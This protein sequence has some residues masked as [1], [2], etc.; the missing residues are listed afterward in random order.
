MEHLGKCIDT[1]CFGNRTVYNCQFGILYVRSDRKRRIE[2]V[3]AFD[4]TG[5][6]LW[7]CE[8]K[9]NT[10]GKYKIYS[11]QGEINGEYMAK[12]ISEECANIVLKSPD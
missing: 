3:S 12:E 9:N 7:S 8:Y 1:V 5:T 6:A 11:K 2:G 4:Y 10:P